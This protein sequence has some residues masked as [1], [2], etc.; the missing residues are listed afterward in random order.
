MEYSIVPDFISMYKGLNSTE[1]LLMG[2]IYSL[3]YKS[4]ECFASNDYLAKKLNVTTRTIT[5]SLS[6]LEDKNLIKVEFIN[7]KR[8]IYLSDEIWKNTSTGIEEFF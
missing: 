4:N 2:K 3:T 8:K 1:K 6:K 5:S 7:Y